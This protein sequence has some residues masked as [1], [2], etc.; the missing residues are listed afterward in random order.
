MVHYHIHWSNSK[1][2]WQAFPTPESA[3]I[4]AEHLAMPGETFTIDRF[5]DEDCA[6][7]KA[8]AARLHIGQSA[9]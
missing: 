4:G 2:D 7:C 5:D 8:V 6:H 1:F 9:K 3:Q